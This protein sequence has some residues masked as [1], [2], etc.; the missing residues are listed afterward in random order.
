[1]RF[2]IGWLKEHLEFQSSIDDLC[3]KL[4]SIGLEVEECKDL[5]KSGDRGVLVKFSKKV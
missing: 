2:T 3:E 1:M 4:T 5:K